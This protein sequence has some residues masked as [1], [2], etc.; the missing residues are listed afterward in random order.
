[1]AGGVDSTVGGILQRSH[2]CGERVG[3]CVQSESVSEG[4]G[5]SYTIY[6]MHLS[7]CTY[8][9]IKH[10][11]HAQACSNTYNIAHTD[12][13]RIAPELIIEHLDFKIFRGEYAPRPP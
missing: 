2:A 11:L 5:T 1:M 8:F 9:V 3:E 6:L 12:I 10:G 4:Q 13:T 7:Q